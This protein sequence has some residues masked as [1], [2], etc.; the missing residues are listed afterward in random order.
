MTHENLVSVVVCTHN[1][2]RMLPVALDALARQ[3]PPAGGFE[4]VIVDDHS[5][6]GSAELA[7]AA[8]AKVVRLTQ[9]EDGGLAAARN[10]GIRAASGD[11]V[12]FT[13]DDCE[14]APT[15][16]RELIEPMRDPTV[17][18]VAGRTVP[19]SDCDLVLRYLAR[20]NPLAPLPSVLLESRRPLFRLRT[21]LRDNL[22]PT[23]VLPAGAPLYSV[24]GANMAFR[25][26]FLEALGGFD[27]AIKFGGEEEDLCRRAHERPGGALFVY[28]PAAEVRHHYRP[29]IK[30]TLRR[31]RAYGRGNARQAA[32]A[33]GV[34][35]I[36]YPFPLLIAALAS[37]VLTRPRLA[38][39]ALALPWALYP[40]WVADGARRRDPE[41]LLFAYLQLAQEA[42]TMVGEVEYLIKATRS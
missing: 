40:G 3:H 11:L 39:V 13:D 4:V 23:R 1:G 34:W 5:T 31:A 20:R 24:V 42:A 41:A 10:A 9:E 2:A 8:G 14:P 37:A 26:S 6:D 17:D 18:G 19:A 36:V 29:G 32:T 15:W 27:P 28:A 33:P 7:A 38:P 25:L 30:D 21:Y 16:L 35:P 12:A 22:G